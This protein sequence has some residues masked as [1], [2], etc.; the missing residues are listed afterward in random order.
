[1]MLKT[2]RVVERKA[3]GVGTHELKAE[4]K[5]IRYWVVGEQWSGM[6]YELIGFRAWE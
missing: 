4:E 3:S 1:M 5:R 2:P 6:E